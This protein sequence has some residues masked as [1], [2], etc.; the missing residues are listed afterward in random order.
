MNCFV[1]FQLLFWQIWNMCFG[2]FGIQ[3]GFVLQ[4]VN[5]SCI[6]EMLGVDIDVVLGLWIVVLLIGL[7]VQLVIGY[8][9]DCIWMCWGWC[10]LF[11]MI[12]VVLIML[13]LLV[14]LNLLMLWIV[15]GM[16]WVFD[17]LINVL[18]EFFCVFVGDQL[19]LC[20]CLVGY[21]MQ[22]FFIGVGVIVVSFLL[23]ILVYFGV[24][25]MVV[26][27]EVLDI[28]CYVFYFGVVVLLVVIIWMV[29]SI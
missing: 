24:V 9:F 6:F 16:L 14:M 5:V 23:F 4:N 22:S 29:F 18:M 21:V 19:V 13:V 11:F 12:G 26:V 20:Q 7:L 25:N 27:G 17:V 15:V 2:F 28:V 1:K 8:L 3:F 10:C